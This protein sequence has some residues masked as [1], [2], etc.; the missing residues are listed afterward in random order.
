MPAVLCCGAAGGGTCRGLEQHL[1]CGMCS[2]SSEQ[3]L[4][5]YSLGSSGAGGCLESRADVLSLGV[6]QG[7]NVQKGLK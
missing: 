4:F 5:L 3:A 1:V 2:L 7:L 6:E